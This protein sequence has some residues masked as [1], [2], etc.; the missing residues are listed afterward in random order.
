[1][2]KKLRVL[3][4]IAA[5]IITL[6]VLLSGC[7]DNVEIDEL[8]IVTGVAL[9]TAETLEN[10]DLT[11][12]IGQIKQSSRGSA[13]SGSS[14]GSGGESQEGEFLTFQTT[15]D[16]ILKGV[17]EFNRDSRHKLMMHHN[18][19]L[20]FGADLAAQGIQKHLDY[21]LRD[22]QARL[23]VPVIVVDGRAD[24]I[25]KTPLK[26]EE[27]SGVYIA[28]M[29]EDLSKISI[30]YR[31]R[32]VDF[33]SKL[34]DDSTAPV[35]PMLKIEES[36]QNKEIV[37][38]GFAVF[39]GDRM[40]GSIS[41]AE[42]LG[43]IFAMDKVKS[44]EFPI[45]DN[46]GQA[47]LHI[48][49]LKTQ[50]KVKIDENGKVSAALKVAATVHLGEQHG[51]ENIPSKQK[52]DYISE[53]AQE[54]LKNAILTTFYATQFMQ[55]D[56]YGFGLSVYQKYPKKWKAMQENWDNIY[57]QM[58]LSVDVQVKLTATGQ[59]NLPLGENSS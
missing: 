9:D 48:V 39:K 21:F 23:E 44:C 35:A 1:M 24:E 19:A 4:T 33:I 41:N 57:S 53:L 29:F 17:S 37:L 56:I 27:I 5:I 32:L 18:Q 59:I 40:V 12:Q 25:L 8:F 52:L 51:F 26:E 38:S 55:T 49:S 58:E 31:E 50:R 47:V 28:G 11:V 43:Y 14:G 15:T 54:E 36:G 30:K 10:I 22:Q 42:T 3:A 16:T 6:S 20:L 34:L 45:K 2:N 7:W 13:Q 46:E